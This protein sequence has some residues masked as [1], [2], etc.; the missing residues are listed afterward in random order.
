MLIYAKKDSCRD[1]LGPKGHNTDTLSAPKPPV[2]AMEVIRE[3]N[4]AQETA[5]KTYQAK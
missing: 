4:N 5:C 3:L 1:F 2:R